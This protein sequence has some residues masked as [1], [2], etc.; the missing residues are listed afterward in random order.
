MLLFTLK[1]NSGSW[2]TSGFISLYCL[3]FWSCRMCQQKCHKEIGFSQRITG[4]CQ[5]PWTGLP[6][7]RFPVPRKQMILKS[8]QACPARRLR[9]L[10]G[11]SCLLSYCLSSCCSHWALSPE[12]SPRT[13]S[14]WPLFTQLQKQS[15]LLVAGNFSRDK[16][17]CLEHKGFFF[18]FYFV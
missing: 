12:P 4:S 14:A 13:C 5:W 15:R 18:F 6:W 10:C 9:L 2:Q 16:N 1:F 8:L 17:R 11:W 3:T 7:L